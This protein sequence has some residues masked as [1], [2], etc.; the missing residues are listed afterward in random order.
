MQ[1]STTLVSELSHLHLRHRATLATL[2][3]TPLNNPATPRSRAI[4]R[5][6]SNDCRRGAMEV[7]PA[8][9]ELLH[10]SR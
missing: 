10:E 6:T 7:V 5:N 3:T 1:V 8:V 4:W 2:G 9:A